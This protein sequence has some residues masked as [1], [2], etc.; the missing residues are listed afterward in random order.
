LAFQELLLTLFQ[1]TNL[2][3]MNKKKTI[4]SS[5]TGVKEIQ[6][7]L[8][9]FSVCSG[10]EAA[11]VAWESLGWECK[12]LCDF[13]PFPQ[14]V[15]KHLYPDVPFYSNMLNLLNDEK[16]KKTDF[17]V[18]VGGTP[19]QAFSSA[20]LGKG[21]DDERSQLAIK[22]GTILDEKSPKYNVWENVDG[23]FDK[24]HK[25]GLC[26]IISSFTGVDFRPEQINRGGGVVQGTKRSIAYRVFDS[27]YFGVPQRR[28]RVYIVGYRGTDWRV[29]AAILFDK[30]CFESPEKKNQRQRDE[31]TKSILGQ[32]RIAGT[33]TKSYSQTLTDG[34]G[35]ESTSNYWVDK[36]GIRRFTEKELLRLQGFPDD[37]LDFNIDGKKPSYSNVKGIVGNS[38]TVNVMKW[39]GNRIQIV[40]DIL[41]SK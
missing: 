19:C 38:M 7:P 35:K 24:K 18:F 2:L 15:L 12:G 39:I 27:Q 29:P 30:G 8:S 11:T 9:Y 25:E 32:I 10:M 22:Y 4:T 1:Q 37:Y 26:D 21:M 33:V 16:F 40:E 20:G 13:A 5:R 31:R 36:K 34:F 3:I 23:V 28:K 17:D 6:E 41:N 14:K